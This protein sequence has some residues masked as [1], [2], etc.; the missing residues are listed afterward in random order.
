MT[1]LRIDERLV[2]VDRLP[3]D[4]FPAQCA[5]VLRSHACSLP[6][7]IAGADVPQRRAECARIARRPSSAAIA[8][9]GAERRYV[10]Y[11]RDHACRH[12]FDQGVAAAFGMA[13][14]DEDVRRRVVIWQLVTRDAAGQRDSIA[15]ERRGAN[16]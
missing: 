14:A 12:R 13:A 7:E 6:G 10:G 3:G 5:I 1:R 16:A 9:D 15:Q 8:G 2:F 4:S 11:Y